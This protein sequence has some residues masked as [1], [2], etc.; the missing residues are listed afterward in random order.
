MRS[1]LV[2]IGRDCRR[3]GLDDDEANDAVQETFLVVDASV[4]FAK[5]GV[6]PKPEDALKNVYA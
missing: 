4:A 5:A 2:A 3:L 6:D 1:V